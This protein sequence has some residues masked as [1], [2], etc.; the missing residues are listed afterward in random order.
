MVKVK[1]KAVRGVCV[2]VFLLVLSQ[3][4]FLLLMGT[5]ELFQEFLL[6]NQLGAL[7]SDL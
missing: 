1:V 6:A 4:I 5:V 7:E 3:C 2:C